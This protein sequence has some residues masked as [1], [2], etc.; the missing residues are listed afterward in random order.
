MTY[1]LIS[2]ECFDS[3]KYNF[4]VRMFKI[5]MKCD[6]FKAHINYKNLK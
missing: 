6:L 4:M 1:V 2:I 5:K 3:N